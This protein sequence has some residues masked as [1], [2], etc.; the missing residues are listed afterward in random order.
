MDEKIV[1]QILDELFSS[2]EKLETDSAAILL[3]LQHEGIATKERLAPYLEQSSRMSEVRWRAARVRMGA[4]LA[5]AMKTSAPP[6]E[7]KAAAPDPD[8]E[9][10][11]PEQR[12]ES[13]AD[14]EP[15]KE[16]EPTSEPKPEET[17]PKSSEN[18]NREVEPKSEH[19]ADNVTEKSAPSKKR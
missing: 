15:G 16:S 19:K 10:K 2:F 3:L 13:E 7:Q 4:L 11:Q 18:A 6:A 12:V 9:K 8:L 5:S 17:V 1:A 14:V